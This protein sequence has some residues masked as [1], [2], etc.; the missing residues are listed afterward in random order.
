MCD[1]IESTPFR[2]TVSKHPNLVGNIPKCLRPLSIDRSSTTLAVHFHACSCM[3]ADFWPN[4]ANRSQG[5][6]ELTVQE[7]L[8]Y[9]LTDGHCGIPAGRLPQPLHKSAIVKTDSRHISWQALQRVP[10]LGFLPILEYA[11]TIH[12]QQLVLQANP[13]RK[14]GEG[15]GEMHP[16]CKPAYAGLQHPRIKAFRS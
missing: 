4:T 12:L 10:N 14:F 15:R 2:G 11:V 16:T 9:A 1:K 6:S 3:A 8:C 5:P 13:R 7:P